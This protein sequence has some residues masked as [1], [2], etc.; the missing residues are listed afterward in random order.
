MHE[1]C[2]SAFFRYAIAM[3]PPYL[4]YDDTA[5]SDV[6]IAPSQSR[7]CAQAPPA[8][9]FA[10][11]ATDRHSPQESAGSHCRSNGRFQ[12]LAN[13]LILSVTPQPPLG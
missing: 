4:P 7:R 8:D 1:G 10:L 9:P 11:P 12:V 5:Q 13:K 6:G 2:L 3:Q